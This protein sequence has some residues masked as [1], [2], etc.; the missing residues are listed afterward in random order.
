MPV[1]DGSTAIPYP[2]LIDSA[3]RSSDKLQVA[4]EETLG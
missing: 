2:V 3:T 4:S 1:P